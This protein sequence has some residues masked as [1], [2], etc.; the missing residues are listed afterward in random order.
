[1]DIT[2][3][4]LHNQ[5]LLGEK[6][7]TPQ[8]VVKHLGAVQAQDFPAAKWSLGQRIAGS[9]DQEMEQ[10]YNDGKIIRTH[11]MRPTWHFVMPEDIRWMLELTSPQV[12]KLMGHYNRKLELDDKLFAKT[13]QAI[14]KALT[15]HN[16]LTRQELKQVLLDIGIKTDVQRLGHIVSWAELDALICSGPKRGKQLTYA[17]LDERAPNAKKLD[18]NESLATLALT[19]FTSH[20]P[21]QLKDFSWWSGLSV[22]DST[23][24]LELIRSKLDHETINNKTY[25]F[26]PYSK[27][28]PMKT[29]IAWLVSVY[30]EYVISYKDRTD[31]SEA[32]DR[33][34]EKI[35]T[36]GNAFTATII[37]NGKIV[38]T[39]KR[40]LKKDTVEIKLNYFR[41]MNNSE[42]EAV[43]LAA[44]KYGKFLGLTAVVV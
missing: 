12:K 1:M 43:Q 30:D 21:A 6:F 36:M 4:R 32:G 34:I 8:Q 17:L 9:T 38:G 23:E 2:S 42:Q 22:K 37:L 33:D 13:N 40:T 5:H 14:V 7:K 18:R 44:D 25:Y 41:K 16:Y 20:G 31:I 29:P 24:A 27:L 28:P 3:L 19:Y 35:L 15:G 10:A 11:V 39:W 26:S